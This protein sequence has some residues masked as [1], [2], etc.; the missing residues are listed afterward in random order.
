MWISPIPFQKV[1]FMYCRWKT[2]IW[3]WRFHRLTLR[4]PKR[5]DTLSFRP[6][7]MAEIL[8][9]SRMHSKSRPMLLIHYILWN[10]ILYTLEQILLFICLICHWTTP[11]RR[12]N[13]LVSWQAEVRIFHFHTLCCME[14]C[15][16]ACYAK[17]LIQWSELAWFL[18]SLEFKRSSFWIALPFAI[19]FVRYLIDTFT[20]T[21]F[22][23][24]K[25][26]PVR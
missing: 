18:L 23:K 17:A 11:V 4:C 1:S 22:F 6:Q 12:T 2:W 10:L 13:E 9:K 15:S 8:E 21:I 26:S 7:Q 25:Y 24:F 16:S 14:G 5:A 3:A 20:V 19:M